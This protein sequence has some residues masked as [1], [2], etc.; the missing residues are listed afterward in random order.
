MIIMIIITKDG[1]K[2]KNN[3]KMNLEYKLYS[4]EEQNNFLRRYIK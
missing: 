4:K 3:K 2:M 1:N